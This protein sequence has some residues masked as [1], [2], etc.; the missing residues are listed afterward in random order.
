MEDRSLS[1]LL[2]ISAYPLRLYIRKSR[3]RC[4]SQSIK[5]NNNLLC[6]F[7]YMLYNHQEVLRVKQSFIIMKTYYLLEEVCCMSVLKDRIVQ[8]IY[9]TAFLYSSRSLLR[10]A[11]PSKPTSRNLRSIGEYPD[12]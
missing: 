10:N 9:P 2:Y 8:Y 6:D 11:V 4:Q 1:I 7:L 12:I 5:S 3:S